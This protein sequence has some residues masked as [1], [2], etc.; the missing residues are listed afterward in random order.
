MIDSDFV[1][2]GGFTD[3]FGSNHP[4][5]TNRDD[6]GSGGIV[7]LE[8]CDTSFNDGVDALGGSLG[9]LID[10]DFAFLPGSDD[11]FVFCALGIEFLDDLDGAS[12]DVSVCVGGVIDN[13]GDA[14][15]AVVDGVDA[16]LGEGLGG[17]DSHKHGDE[18]DTE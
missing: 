16:L 12:C 13:A 3:G 15:D 10:R 18:G 7:F 11:S 14:I 6:R 2:A 17:D 9:S 1:S 8:A 4:G 5:L